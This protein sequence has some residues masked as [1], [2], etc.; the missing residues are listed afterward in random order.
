MQFKQNTRVPSRAR[1]FGTFLSL[2]VLAATLAWPATGQA[3]S[4]RAPAIEEVIVTARQREESLIDVPVAITAFTAEDLAS[5]GI[6]D[7]VSLK[8]YSPGF[9][10]AEQ[11]TGRNDRSRQNFLF[12]GMRLVTVLG[13]N[14]GGQAFI[15]GAPNSAGSFPGM[16]DVERVEVIK[17]PQ[18]AYFGRGTFSGAVNFVLKT[19]ANEWGGRADLDV[20]DNSMLDANLSVEGPLVRDKLNVRVAGRHY[21]EGGQYKNTADGKSLG[22]RST[23]ALSL[24]FHLTPT[25]NLS[26][27]LFGFYFKDD[28]GPQAAVAFTRADLNCDAGAGAGTF[29][30]ICGKLPR[31]PES[32]IGQNNVL[33]P[34]FINRIV[35]NQAGFVRIFN[36]PFISEMGLARHAYHGSALIDWDSSNGIRLSSITSYNHQAFQEIAD[37]DFRDT[38]NL[39]N[40][41]FPAVAG[42]NS[43][44]NFVTL[45]ESLD[46]DF[47]QELRLT[48]PDDQRFRY[49]AGFNYNFQFRAG[50]NPG[51][52]PTGFFAA[53][54]GQRSS[55]YTYGVYA[56]LYYDIT[57]SLNLGA[58]GRYQSD[59]IKGTTPTRD[60]VS[61]TFKPFAPRVS[62]TYKIDEDQTAYLQWARGYRS[63]TFNFTFLTQ[64]QVVRD[65]V[66][67]VAGAALEVGQ[68]QFDSYEAGYK[69]SLWDSR[70]QVATAVYYGKWRDQQ[71]TVNVDLRPLNIPGLLAITPTVP[72][73]LTVLKGIE[74]EG[75]FAATEQLTLDATFAIADS[76]IRK[77]DCLACVTRSTGTTNVKGNRLP[78]VPRSKG[79]FTAEWRDT[80][81]DDIE[82][83][84]RGDY[85]YTGGQFDTEANVATNG[86]SHRFNFKA[87]LEREAWL[88]EAYV[89]NA[90]QDRTYGSFELVTD[91]ILG[92]NG[93]LASPPKKRQFG[94]RASYKF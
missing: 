81:R 8:D 1:E 28:D 78:R 45:V 10:I 71:V 22:D 82:W 67:Q 29:N 21:S 26:V 85:L 60:R 72:A 47:S 13:T 91:N 32:R 40:P 36:D 33:T 35:Y 70:V 89:N 43:F 83:Y 88:F 75:T 50:A 11:N 19:P 66:Q 94:A 90:F 37:Q 9:Y 84:L 79:S 58:E 12:R 34:G 3:Q 77:F 61:A 93:F 30:Y 51:E 46:K 38:S 74:L 62:L 44:R 73:G 64:P 18:S 25:D 65:Y 86:V 76:S 6:K 80:F 48:S 14:P 49:T 87:G 54:G 68:E 24:M 56:G 63:G 17:G 31:L 27:K 2:P 92:G 15:N 53:G 4:G 41:S 55:A 23:D 5:A 57:E 42:V 59:K 7:Y 39:P 20:A 69:A 52:Q 16:L